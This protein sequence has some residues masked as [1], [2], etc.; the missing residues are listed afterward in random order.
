MRTFNKLFGIGLS[1]TGTTS[2]AAALNL[3]GIPTVHWPRDMSEFSTHRGAVDITVSCRFMELDAIY[4][5]SL[6]VYTCRSHG[7]WLSSAVA[8]Y[9]L[10][11]GD[12]RLP[13][14]QKQFAQEAD[15]RLYGGLQPDAAMLSLAYRKHARR[16]GAYFRRRESDLLR[17]NIAGGDGWRRLCRFLELPVL[18]LPFPHANAAK[19]HRTPVPSSPAKLV[20]RELSGER[21]D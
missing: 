2:L 7:P 10:L 5:G 3:I 8:H 12:L 16:V 9:Q 1:R 6:F 19:T 17:L 21:D 13:D 14:G 11:G 4:P 15:L 20:T 18:D